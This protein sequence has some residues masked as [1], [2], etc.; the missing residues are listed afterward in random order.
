MNTLQSRITI[1][2]DWLIL[3]VKNL[4]L[5]K[6]KI[7]SFSRHLYQIPNFDN[8]NNQY[9]LLNHHGFSLRLWINGSCI[10][11]YK[12]YCTFWETYIFNGI[13]CLFLYKQLLPTIWEKMWSLRLL[14]LH[15]QFPNV[16][17]EI[18][19]YNIHRTY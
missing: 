3:S 13:P 15:F 4:I 2:Y 18:A 12:L 16:I 11:C 8:S 14:L 9:I 19:H 6:M 7:L 1:F 5:S 17:L 10:M